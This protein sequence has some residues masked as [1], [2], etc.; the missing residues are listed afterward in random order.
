MDAL[1]GWNLLNQAC[2]REPVIAVVG[3]GASGTLLAA[4]LLRAAATRRFPA[5]VALIDRH[6]RHGLG[7]AYSTAHPGHLLNAPAAQLS[8]LADD[9]DHLAQWAGPA[10]AAGAAFL[11][12]HAYGRYLRETLAE[13]QRLAQPLAQLS[14]LTSE[15]VAIRRNAA[16]R[17]LRL[18]LAGGWLDA[19]IAVLATGSLPPVLPFAAPA[20]RRIIADPWAP[21]A[22][23]VVGNC[24]A[25]IVVGTG[26][27]AIDIAIALTSANPMRV[28]HAVS[29]HGLLPRVHRGAPGRR[30]PIWLPVTATATG[31]VRLTELSWQIRSAMAAHADRWQDVVD[32]LRPSIPGLWQRMPLAD[33]R[34]FLRHVARYWEVHRHLMPPDTAR[35]VAELRSA[36]RLP[37]RQGLITEVTE[38]DG[39][40]DVRLSQ[41]D[42]ATEITGGWLINGTGPGTD[43]TVTADPLQ[44]DLLASGLA[45]PD[46]L[47][48]GIDATTGGAVIDASGAP[49]DSIFTLGPPLRGLLYE[50]TAIPEIRRQAA[51]LA[52][53]LTASNQ[54]HETRRRP[55]SAA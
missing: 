39:Q 53:H 7:Q 22:L 46:P 12:R 9:P 24:S 36:G 8:A 43:V 26:L 41:G 23:D 10:A 11:P 49:S 45:R 21:G 40:V 55:G 3:G 5:R 35:R 19:D 47:L 2:G 15:V 50:T 31:P 28:V 14:Q 42:R 29:R 27:T 44:R 4:H 1:R 13:A 6:G 17:P 54:A 20:S 30:S 32:A 18:A 51:A 25:V 34:M 38:H 37:V 16:G 52:A 33:K 48:L